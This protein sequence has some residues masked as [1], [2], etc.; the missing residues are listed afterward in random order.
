MAWWNP[1]LGRR[2]PGEIDQVLF[3]VWTLVHFASG[4][5]LW[6]I[7]TPANVAFM[8]LLAFEVFEASGAGKMVF[9]WLG[10][11]KWLQWLPIIE[12]QKR[13]QGDS[14]GNMIVDMIVGILAFSLAFY[15][16]IPLGERLDVWF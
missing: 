15:G 7:G 1:V 8:L 3:D 2:G 11:I 6:K 13:Y 5:I 4:L 16:I 14:W 10:R 12:S 9:N